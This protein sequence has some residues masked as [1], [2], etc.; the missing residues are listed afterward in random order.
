VIGKQLAHYEITGLLGKGG[1]GEVYRALDG[2]LGREVAIK[3]L[4]MEMSQDVDRLARFDREA[5]SLATLQHPNVASAYG[6]EETPE[7]RFLVMELVEGEGLDERMARGPIDADEVRSIAA[8]IASGLEAAHEKGI[9]HRDLKPANIRVSPDGTVKVLDFG[10]AKAW[11]G[12]DQDGDIS[13]SPTMTAHT[14]Q[15][16]I[17]GT[18]GYMSPEQARGQAVNKQTD[19]WAFGVILWEMLTGQRLFDGATVSDVM[20]GVLRADINNQALPTNTP[21]ALRRLLRRCLQRDQKDRLRDIGDAAL[22]LKETDAAEGGTESEHE[23][24]GISIPA[25][26]AIL[27]VAIL[28][29]GLATKVLVGGSG[30]NEGLA[31]VAQFEQKTFGDQA[32]FNARFLPDD[33]GIVFSTA[34]FGN[35]PHLEVLSGSGMASVRIGPEGTTL[36]SVSDEG[37][38]AVLTD[39]EFL[40]HRV[41]SG[42]LARMSIDGAPRPLIEDVRD[43]DWGPEN[44]LAI[45][46]KAGGVI[47]LEYPIGN[48]L[49]ETSGYISDPRVSPDGKKVAFHDHQWRDDDRGWLKMVD[50]A[51]LVTTLSQEFWAIE[52][53]VWTPDGSKILFSGHDSSTDLSPMVVD[54]GAAQVRPFLAVPSSTTILDLDDLGRLLI[55]SERQKHGVVAHPSGSQEGIDL[56][57]QGSNWGPILAPD[58][59]TLL[60]TNGRGGSNY[61]V[62]RRTTGGSPLTTMGEGGLMEL[63]PDGAWVTASIASPLG[64]AI[65]PIGT[66]VEKHLDLGPIVQMSS[67]FWFPNSEEILIVG[68]EVDGANRIYRQK[69]SGGLP[70]AIAIEGA[71]DYI[72]LTLDGSAMLGIGPDQGHALF[73]IDGSQPIPLPGLHIG[74]E[75]LAWNSDGTA[76]YVAE[77]RQVPVTLIRVDLETQQRTADFAIGPEREPG[78]LWVKISGPVFDPANGYSYGYFKTLSR[79]FVVNGAKW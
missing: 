34:P 68:N 19:V 61:S 56:T 3:I 35:V 50:E 55:L 4:P 7:A 22:E 6:L 47:R 29:T 33:Q 17:L 53:L 18:A 49:Y 62:V 30:Q 54:V 23:A 52:G 78:L 20:A 43:A 1:M 51:G 25:W 42:T 10:L 39:V 21:Q 67:A 24:R 79:L 40:H 13:S 66:G 14:I 65:Y 12:D 72:R 77:N 8:Q 46:R 63:S 69:I 75:I 45:V 48:V 71:E 73:P 31:P 28:G 26:L 11:G 41:L 74:D 32:I 9:V 27:V 64:L 76:L 5:R 59:K 37:E 16:V 58:N 38:L 70:E 36:L 15:G 2:K 60:F 44:E 57:W